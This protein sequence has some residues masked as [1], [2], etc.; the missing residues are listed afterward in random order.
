M[1]K[2]TTKTSNKTKTKKQ[3]MNLRTLL[4][5][6][7][8]A[9]YDIES[10]L[11]KALPKMAKAAT[12]PELKKGFEEHLEETKNQVERLEEIHRIL[13]EE[14]KKLKA[15]GIRGLVKD[16]EWV[17]KNV[18]PKEAMDA[19]LA[20]AAQYVEHYEMAGYMAAIDWAE[21]LAETEI[22]DLLND[23]LEEEIAADDKLAMVGGEIDQNLV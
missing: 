7:V 12:T 2:K 3:D 4:I 13:G 15:E 8:N 20:R 19:N 14:P 5:Q 16:G 18:V 10:E 1:A 11:V 23:T 9:L 6:K 22:V 17:I 21:T